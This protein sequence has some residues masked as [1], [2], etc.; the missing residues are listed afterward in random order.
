MY[1]YFPYVFSIPFSS[2][3][4][5]KGERSFEFDDTEWEMTLRNLY[6]FTYIPLGFPFLVPSANQILGFPFIV[7]SV[8]QSIYPGSKREATRARSHTRAGVIWPVP[9]NALGLHVTHFQ[10][11]LGFS[12]SSYSQISRILSSHSQKWLRYLFTAFSSA[13]FW[14]NN[15]FANLPHYG[16]GPSDSFKSFILHER[17]T[18]MGT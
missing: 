13:V 15:R 11:L 10:K 6:P 5:R 8:S 7:F 17:P 2:C 18:L 9:W 4:P 12:A 14:I 3:V 1:F 16:R